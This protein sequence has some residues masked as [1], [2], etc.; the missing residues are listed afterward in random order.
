MS[1][2]LL[3]VRKANIKRHDSS[4]KKL[5]SFLE[6]QTCKQQSEYNCRDE[7]P[8][9]L[10]HAERH[11]EHTNLPLLGTEREREGRVGQRRLHTKVI[12]PCFH[13][14]SYICLNDLTLFMA[15]L[16]ANSPQNIPIVLRKYCTLYFSYSLYYIVLHCRYLYM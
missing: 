6:R 5:Y 11:K 15:S 13:L 7:N 12:R 2:T 14:K 1:E 8:F 4:P 10:R 3:N 9:I 16:K